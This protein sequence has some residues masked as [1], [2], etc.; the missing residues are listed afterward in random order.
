M[1]G[2][3]HEFSPPGVPP[4]AIC[5]GIEVLVHRRATELIPERPR[6][7]RALLSTA[8]GVAVAAI[9]AVLVLVIGSPSGSGL[10][11]PR[12]AVAAMVQSL[13]GDGVLHWV[14]EEQVTG[15]Q[16]SSG[17]P[18]RIESEEWLDLSSGDA[19]TITKTYGAGAAEPET[20]VVWSASGVL[21]TRFEGDGD[22]ATLRRG[23]TVT[24][25]TGIDEIRATLARADRG[26]S[27]VADAGEHAGHPM[28]VVTERRER[29]TQR[30]WITREDVPQLVRSETAVVSPNAPQ[31]IVTTSTTTTWQVLSPTP[32][33]LADVQIPTDAKRVP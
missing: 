26:E 31:P 12:Q 6:R 21:W 7:R 29:I 15:G 17:W 1:N 32:E 10:L 23:A 20:R 5:P 30:V 14:R 24:S 2:H 27:E 19:R 28:V 3:A 9:C 11:S 16:S 25:S 4:A 22:Q 8:G 13:N 33:T 18:E